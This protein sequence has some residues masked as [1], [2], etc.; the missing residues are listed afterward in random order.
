MKF[1][2]S[3]CPGYCCSHPRI[4]VSAHDISRLAAHF[5][6]SQRLAKSRYTYR[7]RAEDGDE[8]IL[9]HHKDHIYKSVCIFLDRESRRC[10]IYHARPHVCRK[11]PYASK[12]GYYEFLKFERAHHDDQD[13]VP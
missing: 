13:H 4:A 5:G 6:I 1:N 10:T 7:Y 8:Q 3:R 2:C 12:C 11:Y 9:R